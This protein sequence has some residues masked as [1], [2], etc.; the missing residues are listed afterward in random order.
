V[1]KH[2]NLPTFSIG[3]LPIYGDL[4]LAP[5]DGTTDLPFRGLCRR[6]GSAFSVTEFVNALDVLE[7]HPRY[8]KRHAFEPHHRP[9]SLQLLGDEAEQILAAALHLVPQV[10][11][12][13]IDINLGCQSK[14]VTQRG[15]GAALLKA[16]GKIAE[17][18]RLMTANFAQ[19]ITGK[20]RLGWDEEQL[21]YLEVAQIIQDNGGAMVAVHGRTRQQAYRG[22]ARWEP[23]REIKSALHIPVIGNGDVRTVADID[24]IKAFTGCDA[25]MIGRAA[26]G[27]PWIFSR[28]D[29]ADVPPSIV[30]QTLRQHLVDMLDFYGERG[31]ITFRK[32]LKAY[33]APYAI[34]REKLLILLKSQD[35]AFVIQWLDDFFDHLKQP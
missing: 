33:L 25:V 10:K 11:P 16:P 14:N 22:Q 13:M 2:T 9:L 5:M 35:P 26:V 28:I 8:P 6:L 34:P 18:F 7:D 21:N 4:I 32:F 24:R 12:D 29:R 19:P 31:V 27:N 23:I 20:I 3:G 15:A 17:I 1:D 30:H